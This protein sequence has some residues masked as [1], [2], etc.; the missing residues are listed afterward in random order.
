MKRTPKKPAKRRCIFF[1]IPTWTR[2][3]LIKM[4]IQAAE[5]ANGQ[6]SS[7][8]LATVVETALKMSK[9]EEKLGMPHAEGN[10]NAETS[11]T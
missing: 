1:S 2:L 9:I 8:T 7:A 10:A 6:A 5:L 3:S 4:R 11:E